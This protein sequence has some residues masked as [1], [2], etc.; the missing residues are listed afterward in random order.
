MGAG[1]SVDLL[2]GDPVSPDDAV[3][4]WGPPALEFLW[5]GRRLRFGADEEFAVAEL[6]ARG[7]LK[8][9]NRTWRLQLPQ[10]VIVQALIRGWGQ[11]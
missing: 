11:P 5:G 10:L 7:W 2:P 8:K 9:C 1:M 6:R 3:F 4:D